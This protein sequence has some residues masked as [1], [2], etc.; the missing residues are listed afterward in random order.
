MTDKISW[1]SDNIE[2][3]TIDINGLATGI[4]YGT[5]DIIAYKGG[6]ISPS[7]PLTVIS[8]SSIAIAPALPAIL[9]VGS[10]QDFTASGTYSDGSTKDITA[11]AT[12][13]SSNTNIATISSN[14]STTAVTSGKANITASI[15]GITS[16]PVSLISKPK[17]TL[18]DV[19]TLLNLSA[20]L[21]S[22]FNA[23]YNNSTASGLSLDLLGTSNG[24][25]FLISGTVLN[26][27]APWCQIQCTLWVAPSSTTSQVSASDALADL[28]ASL[29][30]IN[31]VEVGNG[32]TA[33]GYGVYGSGL[34][35]LMI[36]YQ[37]VFVLINSFYSHPQSDYVALGPL[38]ITIAERL[39]N[40]AY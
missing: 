37:N 19:P 8:L 26:N 32:S 20:D 30:P 25:E 23:S 33:A 10:T 4:G 21:P 40:Y 17:F 31:I 3:A 35:F 18:A 5:T 34:E 2:T 29:T 12:W 38:G 6:I 24:S 13:I 14:G 7:V 1:T 27:S 22:T 9:A 15:S 16:I 28:S 39:D 36:K 11:Q